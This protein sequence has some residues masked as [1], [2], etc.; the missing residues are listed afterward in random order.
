[1][2]RTWGTRICSLMRSSLAI[3]ALLFPG[4]P[5]GRHRRIFYST[6]RD[7]HRFGWQPPEGR[8]Y[9]SGSGVYST[10]S[11]PFS[12]RPPCCTLTEVTVPP[13]GAWTSFCIF[14]ASTTTTT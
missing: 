13:W 5:R 8:S 7:A 12:A 3:E 2:T 6:G 10:S 4:R 9:A 11:S 1:M 14:I